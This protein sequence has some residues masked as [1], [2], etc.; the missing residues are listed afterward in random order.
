[1]NTFDLNRTFS[2]GL[3]V[4]HLPQRPFYFQHETIQ[5]FFHIVVCICRS[6]QY[7]S[8]NVKGSC[9][10]LYSI[11]ADEMTNKMHTN[12]VSEIVAADNNQRNVARAAGMVRG[13]W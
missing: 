6:F 9:D 10:N 3:L 7:N 8:Q 12:D 13:W 11:C 1:M 2:N 5:P 4:R